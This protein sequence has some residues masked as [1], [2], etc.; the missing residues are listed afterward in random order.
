V[1]ALSRPLSALVAVREGW[2]CAEGKSAKRLP[3][4]THWGAQQRAA[5]R[6][7]DQHQRLS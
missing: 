5:S 3:D 7:S 6:L 1:L 4:R 2:T